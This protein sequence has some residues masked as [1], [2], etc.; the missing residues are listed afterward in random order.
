MKRSF[1]IVSFDI[2]KKNFAFCIDKVYTSRVNKIR[3]IPKKDRYE[4]DGTP[5][6][7]FATELNKLYKSSTNVLMR[8]LDLTEDCDKAKYLDDK[9]YINLLNTLDEYKSEWDKCDHIIIE[10]QMAFRGKHNVMA[11]KL[12]QFVY[13][14]FVIRYK[15]EKKIVDYPAY[16]KTQVLG[17]NKTE[18]KL[19]PKRKKWAIAKS[20]EILEYKK[21]KVGIEEMSKYRKKDDVSD[22]MLM[23]ITYIYLHFKD[24]MYKE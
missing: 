11:V 5:K 13:S 4:K 21:D 1:N 10:K 9:V 14:Y 6:A 8:N 18:V 12:A 23:N 2:G 7:S 24:G 3:Y 22:C 16:H 17:A 19:K 15:G 20:Q